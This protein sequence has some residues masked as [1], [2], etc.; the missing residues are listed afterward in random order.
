MSVPAVSLD[1][2]MGS[3]LR[4]VADLER[5]RGIAVEL[6]Q[7]NARLRAAPMLPRDVA[8]FIYDISYAL[9]SMLDGESATRRA[10]RLRTKYLRDGRSIPSGGAP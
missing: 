6:E 1:T 10:K 9:P 8:D 5:A 2:A 3:F 7:E 4:T